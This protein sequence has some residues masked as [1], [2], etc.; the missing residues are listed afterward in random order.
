MAYVSVTRARLRKSRFYWPFFRFS[1][2]S[3][4]HARSTDGFIGGYLAMGWPRVFWTVTVWRDQAAMRA[5]RDSGAHRTSM[6][7]LAG[8]CDESSIASITRLSAEVPDPAEAAHIMRDHGRVGKL[9]NP[10]AANSAG[11]A[12][13]DG[14]FGRPGQWLRPLHPDPKS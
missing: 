12:W 4:R 7:S 1:Q 8:W 2:A 6:P 3:A 9:P 14:K 11:K 5:F 10:S 13:P